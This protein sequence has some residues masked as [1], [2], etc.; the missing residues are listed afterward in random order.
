MRSLPRPTLSS[1]NASL[2]CSPSLSSG[3]GVERA[4]R[5]RAQ[6]PDE[7]DAP[8]IKEPTAKAV[9][10]AKAA[11]KAPPTKPPPPKPAPAAP[12]KPK[13]VTPKHTLLYR[14][15]GGLGGPLG[16]S[17]SDARVQLDDSPVDMLLKAR[18]GHCLAWRERDDG[19]RGR[20]RGVKASA[21]FCLSGG[22]WIR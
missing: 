8:P 10:P 22:S 1:I 20:A 6:E 16:G 15:R 13:Y 4:C 14:N 2:A 12:P 3:H 7:A 18:D 17:W 5:W 11:T 9:P 21:S 19:Q